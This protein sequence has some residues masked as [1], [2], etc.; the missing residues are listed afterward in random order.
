M[1]DHPQDHGLPSHCGHCGTVMKGPYC[2]VCGQQGRNPLHGFRHALEDVFESFWHIDGRVFRTLR[3]LFVP[4][5]VA[6][7]YLDGHR[8][9]YLPPLRLSLIA[10]VLAFVA[11]S[12]G[13]SFDTQIVGHPQLERA[14]TLPALRQGRDALLADLQ[15]QLRQATA[16]GQRDTIAQ[17]ERNIG[18]ARERA[19]E[20]ERDMLTICGLAPPASEPARPDASTAGWLR[21]VVG[22]QERKVAQHQSEFV[23]A[24]LKALPL[25]VVVLL[26]VFA[27]LLK[28]LHLRSGLHYLEH[29]VVALYGNAWTMLMITV[30]NGALWLERTGGIAATIGSGMAWLVALS[31]PVYFLFQQKRVYAQSWPV[32]IVK[33]IIVSSVYAALL[34]VAVLSAATIQF[35]ML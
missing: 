11:V 6:R 5:Y 2:H 19:A 29:L 28:W 8:T 33:F 13:V 23:K 30:L 3:L 21:R 20:R 22:E 10:S 25:S 18:Y 16:A 1:A 31:I 7:S 15:E 26:P 14:Q 32:T 9:P 12:F 17:L 24:W 35:M 27:L 34:V 4:G